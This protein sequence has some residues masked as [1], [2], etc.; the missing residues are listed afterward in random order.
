[1]FS[2][3]LKGEKC[4][5]TI[6][7]SETLSLRPNPGSPNGANL[8]VANSVTRFGE[9][10]PLGQICNCLWPSLEVLDSIWQYFEHA[11]VNFQWLWANLYCCK[12]PHLE[13]I[14]ERS[15]HTGS[16]QLFT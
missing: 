7:G 8:S 11:L 14:D 16:E 2:S 4:L 3:I 15:G 13:Q 1:M 12:Y 6:K 10:S 9:I 5:L